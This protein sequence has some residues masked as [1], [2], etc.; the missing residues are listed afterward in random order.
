[1]QA[2]VPMQTISDA[3]AFLQHFLRSAKRSQVQL[4]LAEA[5]YVTRA[6]RQAAAV[7]QE[8]L[9][10]MP[11]DRQV[12]TV[13]RQLGLSYLHSYQYNAAVATFTQWL[14]QFPGFPE[15]PQIVFYLA[16]SYFAQSRF[17]AALPLYQQLLQ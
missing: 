15:S 10:S 2:G 1:V 8:L 4:W 13:L 5:L 3:R 7:Y 17:A 6:Y 12:A 16:S 14:E 11:T 9:P